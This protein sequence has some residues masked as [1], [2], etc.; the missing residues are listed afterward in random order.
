MARV[1]KLEKLDPSDLTDED[2]LV[3]HEDGTVEV[4]TF[5]QVNMEGVKGVFPVPTEDGLYQATSDDYSTKLISAD[6]EEGVWVRALRITLSDAMS[7]SFTSPSDTS[8]TAADGQTEV[9]MCPVPVTFSNGVTGRM[10]YSYLGDGS[11]T[12]P[13]DGESNVTL[14]SEVDS[15]SYIEVRFLTKVKFRSADTMVIHAKLSHNTEGTPIV[16]SAAPK[17]VNISGSADGETFDI[18]TFDGKDFTS[19]W[20][21]LTFAGTAGIETCTSQLFSVAMSTGNIGYT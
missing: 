1:T 16:F 6:V 21:G 2:V 11:D 19:T 18:N 15:E 12:A 10:S 9:V 4:T 14:S 17:Y 20:E 5:D 13:F 7:L 3:L 8:P